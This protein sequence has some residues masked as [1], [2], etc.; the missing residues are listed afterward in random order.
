MIERLL[1]K[2]TPVLNVDCFGF[3]A[4]MPGPSTKVASDS[5]GKNIRN[6]LSDF[7]II[8]CENVIMMQVGTRVALKTG[9]PTSIS[10]FTM[11]PVS[12]KQCECEYVNKWFHEVLVLLLTVWPCVGL[13]AAVVQVANIS[14]G[15][16]FNH[17]DCRRHGFALPKCLFG[18]TFVSPSYRRRRCN[19]QQFLQLVLRLASNS[20]TA[21]KYRHTRRNHHHTRVPGRVPRYLKARPF[22]NTR[23]SGIQN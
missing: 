18:R 4:M 20:N 7:K 9:I 22:L 2:G 5:S 6:S 23:Y 13:L 21:R 3:W 1:P 10:V 15:I 14:I 11:A 17:I 19:G 8:H 16:V 12:T